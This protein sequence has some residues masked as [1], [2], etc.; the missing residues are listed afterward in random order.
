MVFSSYKA[1]LL[2]KTGHTQDPKL[3]T[4]VSRAATHNPTVQ[5]PDIRLCQ[6]NM[7]LTVFEIG[8]KSTSHFKNRSKHQNYVQYNRVQQSKEHLCQVS[9]AGC[10][11]SPPKAEIYLEKIY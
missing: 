10:G 11:K 9:G 1:R 2:E 4:G 7:R 5:N 6:L 3:G 8:V